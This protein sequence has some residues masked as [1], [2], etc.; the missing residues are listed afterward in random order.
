MGKADKIHTISLFLTSPQFR[1]FDGHKPFQVSYAQLSRPH[2][3]NGN[4]HVE[5]HLPKKEHTRLLRAIKHQK[6]VSI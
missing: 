2:E 4:H 6:G 3:S 1:K 5:I